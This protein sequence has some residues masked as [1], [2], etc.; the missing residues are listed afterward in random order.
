MKFGVVIMNSE[1]M[2]IN[3]KIPIFYLIYIVEDLK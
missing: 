1:N 3:S 2:Y